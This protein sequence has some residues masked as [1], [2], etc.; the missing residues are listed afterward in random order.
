[1]TPRSRR[2]VWSG[3]DATSSPA[4]ASRLPHRITLTRPSSLID[5][6]S[7]VW[8]KEGAWG[9]W[10]GANTTFIYSVLLKTMESWTRSLLAA[11]FNVPEPGL[12]AG[13]I[14]ILDSPYPVA[15][16]GVAVAAA[17]IAGVILAPLDI[18]RTQ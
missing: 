2:D 4:P 11:L 3:D 10:K 17:G 13:V 5:A 14:D 8:A 6:L 1:M 15:T 16:L 18:V 7:Q 12:L 9:V